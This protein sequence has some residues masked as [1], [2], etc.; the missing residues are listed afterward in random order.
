MSQIKKEKLPT[1]REFIGRAS[2]VDLLGADTVFGRN[3][4]GELVKVANIPGFF[5][6][7][8]VHLDQ[9]LYDKDEVYKFSEDLT[10]FVVDAINEKLDRE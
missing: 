10:Q 7:C 4:R 3:N 2:K 1:I 9:K 5:G 8:D 6:N